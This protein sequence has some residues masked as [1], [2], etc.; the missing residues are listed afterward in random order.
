MDP[1]ARFMVVIHG[2]Y[3]GS[4]LLAGT[5]L[6]IFLWRA[7]HDLT[8]IA[9]Y[10]GL[11][12][13]MIPLAF[14]ANGLLWRRLGAGGLIRL[15]L[16]GNGLAYLLVLVLGNQAPHWVIVLGL[17]RGIAEGFYWSGFHLVTYDSTSDQDR[18]RYF[19][20]QAT[21]NAF[22]T[23]MLPPLAGTIIVAGSRLQTPYGGYELVFGLAAVM[24]I[25]AMALAGRLPSAA[26]PRLSIERVIRL[27]KRNPDWQW[28]TRARLAD[29]FTG[30]LIAHRMGAA[31]VWVAACDRWA[32]A[33]ECAGAD[34]APGHR[35][36]SDA[37]RDAIRL[38]R[39]L[40]A[41]PRRRAGAEHRMLPAAGNP[42]QPDAGRAHRRRHRR[43]GTDA[44]LG[45]LRPGLPAP[46]RRRSRGP[47][48]G[49]GRMTVLA[50]RPI[51]RVRRIR[52]AAPGYPPEYEV[53]RRYADR[54][55]HQ[56]YME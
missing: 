16:G 34:G 50:V 1:C 7:S 11:S 6:S 21:A 20:V 22:L 35:P 40:R 33:R 14:L 39:A 46:E 3:N 12:A 49:V 25:A 45:R 5:F 15:G 18:D 38:H 2:A 28:V 29:G 4:N 53:T 17:L 13:L 41:L 48:A 54:N 10:S 47:P 23:A 37:A 31:G 8:P 55:D 24:L 26:R 32:L 36:R 30:S 51:A 44:D 56:R 19:G 43:R 9:V 27:V 42:G 52:N